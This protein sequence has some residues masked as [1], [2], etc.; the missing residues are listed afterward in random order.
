MSNVPHKPQPVSSYDW[1]TDTHTYDPRQMDAAQ[2][3]RTAVALAATNARKALPDSNSRI[4]KAVA[5]VLDNAVELLDNG[6]ARVTSQHDGVTRYFVVNGACTCPDYERAPV[7]QCKHRI[8][9]GLVIRALQIAKELGQ[10]PSLVT[11]QPAL[12]ATSTPSQPPIP[13]EFIVQIQGKPFITFQ[14]LLHLAH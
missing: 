12:L 5:L 14:G 8:A 1:E 3:W 13:P 9:R 2:I 11:V 7:N 10:A 6:H 4:D